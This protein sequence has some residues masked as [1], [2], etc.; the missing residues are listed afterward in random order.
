MPSVIS[1]SPGNKRNKQQWGK[2]INDDAVTMVHMK[3]ELDV[4]NVTDELRFIQ[5]TLEGMD[6][7]RF[8]S[9][10][11][12]G[13]QPAYTHKKPEAIVTDFLTLVFEHSQEVIKQDLERELGFALRE[14]LPTDIVATIPTVML[15]PLLP[16]PLNDS[17]GLVR[18]SHQFNVPCSC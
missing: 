18:Q 15:R 17:P 2:G 4:R 11:S 12:P 14:Q 7:L 6:N 3:L 1:C 10:K 5:Q 8:L 13:S 9:I 16:S